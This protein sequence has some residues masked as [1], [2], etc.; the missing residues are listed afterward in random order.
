MESLTGGTYAS[1]GPTCHRDE[2]GPAAPLYGRGQSSPTARLPAVRSSRCDLCDLAHLLN[3]LAGPIVDA[4]DD[5]GGYGG[6]AR[7]DNGGMPEEAVATRPRAR[8]STTE[9]RGNYL[10]R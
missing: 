10:A 2:T 9:L 6:S 3:H 1:V 5:G 4:D 8:T 7:R